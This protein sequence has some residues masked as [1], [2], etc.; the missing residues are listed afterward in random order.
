MI[1]FFNLALAAF[2]AI[3]RRCSAASFLVRGGSPAHVP[4]PPYALSAPLL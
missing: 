1:Y 3:P 2:R 4:L